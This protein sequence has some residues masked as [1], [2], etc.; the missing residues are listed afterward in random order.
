MARKKADPRQKIID[1]SLKLAEEKGWRQLALPEIAEAA[2]VS[3][4]E[5]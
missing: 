2:G 3:L 4:S 5:L 1:A